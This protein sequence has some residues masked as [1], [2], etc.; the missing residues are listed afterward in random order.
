MQSIKWLLAAP[1]QVAT[2]VCLCLAIDSLADL[3]G[4]AMGAVAP[5][6]EISGSTKE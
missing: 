6:P 1:Q 2:L 3:G 4:V 5:L